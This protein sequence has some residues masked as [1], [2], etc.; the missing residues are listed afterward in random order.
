ML[1][2][3]CMQNNHRVLI[4]LCASWVVTGVDPEVRGGQRR[5]WEVQA[6]QTG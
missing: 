2:E 6:T 5:S 3:G 1:W 4:T